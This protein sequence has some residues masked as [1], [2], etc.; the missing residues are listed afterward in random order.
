[1]KDWQLA[2]DLKTR[3]NRYDRWHDKRVSTFDF[4]IYRGVSSSGPVVRSKLLNKVVE[5]KPEA[6]SW[7]QE[8]VEKTFASL[9]K[10]VFGEVGLDQLE[11]SFAAMQI[12]IDEATFT[13]YACELL[14]PGT[15]C[16]NFAEF[17]NFHKVVWA[18]QPASVRR[19]AGD[20]STTGGIGMYKGNEANRRL[21]RSSSVPSGASLRELRDNEGM[22][23]SA[24]RRHE[25]S[26]GYLERGRLPALFHDLGLDL[27]INTDVGMT[28]STRL[29]AFLTAQFNNGE[30]ESKDT[31][32]IHDVVEMQNKYIATLEGE[33][34]QRS[35]HSIAY[36]TF[37]TDSFVKQSMETALVSRPQNE[38]LREA[39]LQK[40]VATVSQFYNS[41]DDLKK[42]KVLQDAQAALEAVLFEEENE[43]L[44]QNAQAALESVLFG[45][46]WDEEEPEDLK[47][48]AIAAL[49][50]V[51][52]YSGE[53]AL[54]KD[55]QAALEKVLDA[56]L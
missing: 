44:V 23:R 55:A 14:R 51:L 4:D 43:E 56:D 27:G 40:K 32:S 2:S 11:A 3:S 45:D 15:D 48:S 29:H 24:F 10:T 35:A 53:G 36:P 26:P 6:L 21:L 37:S 12:P 38:V 13:R 46:D 8:L 54:R 52:D 50:S 39:A 47:M 42:R 20:P 49:E 41:V 25:Q 28:G 22:L 17:C 18:N 7:H 16:V 31:Y 33:K 9:E 5:R 34:Q 1:L 30:L 19:F